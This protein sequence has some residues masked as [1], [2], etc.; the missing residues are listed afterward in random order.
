MHSI[1]SNSIHHYHQI[2]NFDDTFLA[3]QPSCFEFPYQISKKH[4]QNEHQLILLLRNLV[5]LRQAQQIEYT[6]NSP[7]ICISF[8]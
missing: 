2:K 1:K 6:S 5:N 4:H 7:L 8:L 3:N